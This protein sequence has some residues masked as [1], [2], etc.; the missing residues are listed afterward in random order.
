[1][2]LIIASVLGARPGGSLAPVEIAAPH[3]TSL[4]YGIQAFLWWDPTARPFDL[5][6]IRL[7]NFTHV[8]QIFS[9]NDIEPERGEYDWSL[10]DVVVSEIAHRELSLVARLDHPPE[11]A[12]VDPASRADGV[13]FDVEAYGAFCGAVAER[14]AGRIAAYQVWNEPNLQREWADHTPDPAGYVTLLGACYHAIKAADPAAIVI[15]AGLAPTGTEPPVA[16]PDE[17][18]LQAL[19]DAGLSQV[20]DVLGLHAP[21]YANPPEMSPAEAVADG[22]L[23]WQVFRHVEDMR[24]IMIANGDADH[25]VA[26]LEFG[27]TT[28]PGIHPDYAWFAVDEATQ[29]DYLVRA[30]QYAAA[31][32]RPWVGLMSTIYIA[33]P[34]WDE[35]FEEYWWAITT[36]GY[37]ADYGVR[38]AYIDLANMEK[39]MGDT[40]IPAR[41]PDAVEN[42]P[43]PPLETGTP[44]P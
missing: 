18:Y 39:V 33:S 27:W 40:I 23:N 32:W 20:Y 25:Q 41:E 28:D 21:G 3:F 1:I 38:Q 24:R 11:W 31:N 8:K 30:Y 43:L 34:L 4:T 13:P 2:L 7:M 26:I 10:A 42:E 44:A 29:A 6:M 37:G 17:R 16:M 35:S 22:Q 5:E 36:P 9:W 19:Y 14:F 15:S 12:V